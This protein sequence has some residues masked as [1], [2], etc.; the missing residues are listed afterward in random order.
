MSITVVLGSCDLSC[1][2]TRREIQIQIQNNK[3]IREYLPA[4]KRPSGFRYFGLCS[5]THPHT[6]SV[7]SRC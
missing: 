3:K 5:T 4:A 6:E 2:P 7:L 1:P